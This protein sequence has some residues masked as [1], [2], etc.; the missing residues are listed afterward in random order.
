MKSININ[1]YLINIFYGNI[2]DRKGFIMEFNYSTII[3]TVINFA[4]LFAI[5]I[6]L[7]KGIQSFKRFIDRNKEL[8]KKV[9]IILNKLDKQ[10][11]KNSIR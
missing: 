6:I 7:Y 1:S 11:D 4:I 5:I 10:N 3:I 2:K 9:D 8:D